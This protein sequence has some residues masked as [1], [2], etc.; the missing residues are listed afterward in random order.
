M[1][2]ERHS[3]NCP[4]RQSYIS[5]MKISTDVVWVLDHEATGATGRILLRF[6]E[7][8]SREVWT[9]HPQPCRRSAGEKK[10]FFVV[11]F[12]GPDCYQ[13]HPFCFCCLFIRLFIHLFCCVLSAN[14][15]SS[16]FRQC[17][18]GAARRPQ[19]PAPGAKIRKNHSRPGSRTLIIQP[20]P[21]SSPLNGK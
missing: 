2:V 3:V 9:R 11:V 17:L 20:R 16:A 1:K 15:L 10:F 5:H 21:A 8:M 6:N 4:Q 12:K 19:R 13:L 18:R 7:Q 14:K